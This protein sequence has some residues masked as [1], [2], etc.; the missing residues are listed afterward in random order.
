MKH[1]ESENG[2]DIKAGVRLHKL[3]DIVNK[4]FL[5]TPS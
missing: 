1:M 3:R 5:I 4:F 2:K